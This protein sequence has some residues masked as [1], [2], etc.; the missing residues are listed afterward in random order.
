MTS[1]ND[2]AG[3]PD[4]RIR[5]MKADDGVWPA[6]VTADHRMRDLLNLAS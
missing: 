5:G 1:A 2:F 6:L 3:H 4:H